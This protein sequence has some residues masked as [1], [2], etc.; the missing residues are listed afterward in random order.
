M[1]PKKK[2]T[3]ETGKG[4]TPSVFSPTKPRDSEIV[5]QTQPLKASCNPPAAGNTEVENPHAT[6][7]N[8][9][10]SE[11]PH[12]KAKQLIFGI[13]QQLE[14]MYTD[15][16]KTRLQTITIKKTTLEGIGQGI[17]QAYEYLGPP[18]HTEQTMPTAPEDGPILSTLKKIQASVSILEQK[19]EDIQTK[20]T[21]APKTY[22]E[23]IK[24]THSTE[25]KVERQTQQRKQREILRQERAKY[26]VTLTMKS[27]NASTQK[28]ITTMSG[29]AIVERCQQAI[30][31][32]YFNNTDNPHII[33]VSKLA[34]SIR[35][36]F[37]TEEEAKTIRS[38]HKTKEDIWS[39]A[40]EGLKF[41][42]PMHGIVVHGVPIAD[43][44]TNKMNDADA[45][46]RLEK[47]NHMKVETITKIT[48]LRRKPKQNS[49]DNRDK[50][51]LHHSVII[52][53]N[54]PHTANKCITNGFYIDYI[55]HAAEKFTPQYQIMQCFNCCDYGH[56][57][58]NCKRH[59]RCGRCGEKHNTRECT[60]T[61]A[62]CFQCK[63]AHEV[64]HSQCPARLAEKDRLEE[65]MGS[66]PCLFDQF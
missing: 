8:P 6:S 31:R 38:L 7:S 4:A 56:R 64:W 42:E 39:A 52:Y 44:D 61:S 21:E 34:N 40:F 41:H 33:G 53:M 47:E 11:H 3:A 62:H 17:Q 28:S 29:K 20:V 30:N 24:S 27:I 13:L 37:Q 57:A 63:G 32:V 48:P 50:V 16:C 5:V 19:Y 26:G 25:P 36:Q 9:T 49:P 2:E 43:L 66:S 51:K 45:I 12:Q 14:V 46:K 55:H 59:T 60:S 35:L 1:P 58:I 22:A 65:L 23:I 15:A 18:C 54:D 10:T